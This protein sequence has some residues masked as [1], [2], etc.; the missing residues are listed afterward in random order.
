MDGT[1]G[2][3]VLESDPILGSGQRTGLSCCA[4]TDV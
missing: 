2:D 4:G 1:V 3:M